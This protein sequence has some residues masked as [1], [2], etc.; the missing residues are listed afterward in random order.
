MHGFVEETWALPL[1][2]NG[3]ILSVLLTPS[4][5]PTVDR[6][7]GQ[8]RWYV[9]WAA[10]TADQSLYRQG[11]AGVSPADQN[12][13]RQGADHEAGI[14]RRDA[15]P[16]LAIVLNRSVHSLTVADL[17]ADYALDESVPTI[18]T[19]TPGQRVMVL[20]DQDRFATVAQIGENPTVDA[21]R[22]Q[23]GAAADWARSDR[24]RRRILEW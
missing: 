24:A 14:G 22:G 9:A 7:G 6:G 11:G 19:Q 8:N 1:V 21:K 20:F 18:L 17:T 16:T 10:G 13:D 12:C 23:R 15:G 3:V 5:R 2:V 4:R